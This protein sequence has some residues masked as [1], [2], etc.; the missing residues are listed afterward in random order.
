MQ[1]MTGFGRGD[2]PL[3][4]GRVVVELR[5]VNHRFLEVRSHAPGGM[6]GCEALVD[7]L[8]RE[9][10]SRGYCTATLSYE[11]PLGNAASIDAKALRSHLETLVAVAGDSGL[12][13]ADLV[14]V[15]AG[16]PDLF[17]SLGGS[18][19]EE[20]EAAVAAAFEIAAQDL[21]AMRASEGE[22]MRRQIRAGVD[23]MRRC[24]ETLSASAADSAQAAFERLKERLRALV[25][26]VEQ[27]LDGRRLEAEAALLA[28]RSDISEEL[29]RLVSHCDQLAA[30]CDASGPV[31]RRMEFL[32]QEMT[33]EA[34]TAG[35]KTGKAEACHVIV[36]L[37]SEIEKVRELTQNVE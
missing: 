18:N 32:L 4:E 6:A 31:G 21:L 9:R 34:G 22:A 25:A 20:I 14:P 10:L 1:S 30:A 16:A 15:L 5:T 17:R 11:G 2:A 37:K 26:T 8:V 24:V 13:L 3:G 27:G 19:R 28:S 36:D 23:A 7:R 12:V 35:A 29:A 33:R